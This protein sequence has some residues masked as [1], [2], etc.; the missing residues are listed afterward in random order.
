MIKQ[1]VQNE[2]NDQIQAEFQSAWL[3]LAYA[4]WFE[5][6]NL[7]GFAHWMRMQ[8]QEEQAHGMKFYNHMLSRGGTV[9]LQ[10]LDKPVADAEESEEVFEKVLE[11]E[12]YITKRIHSL[13]DLAKSEGDYP[14]Q[15]LLHWFIDEQVEEENAERILERLK[16]I[17]DDNASLYMLD[18]ELAGRSEEED[19]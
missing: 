7:E 9:E 8:W 10:A 17:G 15:T 13:Y 3:Y 5:E 19:A 2:I 6:K 18:Q 11:H 14:L 4:A 16:L 1:K 12:R